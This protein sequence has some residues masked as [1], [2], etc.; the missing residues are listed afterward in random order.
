MPE[1]SHDVACPHCGTH[2]LL[3]QSLLGDAGA[4]VNCPA[5]NQT[6]TVSA[7]GMSIQGTAPAVAEV[8]PPEPV[9]DT[10]PVQSDDAV[11]VA[12]ELV[13]AFASGREDQIAQA[14]SEGRF[15]GEYGAEIIAVFDDYK[16]RVGRDASA[17]PFRELLRERWGVDLTPPPDPGD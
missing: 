14:C 1:A 12:F 5:C 13:E 11:A 2:Y 17:A 15:F 3:P 8:P 16:N 7:E 10:R 6:F 9:V 4:R